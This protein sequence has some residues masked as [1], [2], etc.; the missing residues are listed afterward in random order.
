MEPPKRQL[1]FLWPYVEWGGAQIYCIA[2]MKLARESWDI[3]ILMP[4]TSSPDLVSL[5]KQNGAN[6]EYLG[7]AIDLGPANTLGRKLKRRITRWMT[8]IESVGKLRSYDLHQAILHVDF[9]PWQSWLL[10][11]ILSVRKANI[12]FTLHN[13]FP[14]LPIWRQLVFKLRMQLVSRLAGIHIFAANKDARR[15]LRGWISR[16]LWEGIP[17]TYASV[18]R[19]GIE[20]LESEKIGKLELREK[21]GVPIDKFVVLTVGQFVD[22]KGRWVLLESAKEAT[23]IDK[24]I[25]F[26]WVSP[27]LPA[28]DEA[29]RVDSFG[30]GDKFRLIRS[31]T[32]GTERLDVLRFFKVADCFVLP[33]F[34]EGLPIAVLEAMALGLPTISTK[35][36]AIPEAVKHEETGLLVEPGDS[37]ETCKM[38]LRVKN[39]RALSS[40]LSKTGRSFVLD[41]FDERNTAQIAIDAFEK[42]FKD[43]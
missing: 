22:R 37:D 19:L 43:Q 17:V 24:D 26:I 33:S 12:F 35:V 27:N 5:I 8:E 34:I 10:Y 14:E 31:S 23:A 39:D 38:I 25:V 30:L 40:R 42:C 36:F 32:I 3:T 29:A 18:D 41:N 20:S 21:F 4:K 7:S 1:I 28:G 9:A 15:S 13:S 11:A 6:V 16:S 2:I